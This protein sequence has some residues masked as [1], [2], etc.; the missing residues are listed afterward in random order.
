MCIVKECTGSL[1]DDATFTCKKCGKFYPLEEFAKLSAQV[2]ASTRSKAEVAKWR[3]ARDFIEKVLIPETQYCQRCRNYANMV[4][5]RKQNQERGT[6]SQKNAV[7]RVVPKEDQ[8][9]FERA[10]AQYYI[11]QKI[12]QEREESQRKAQEEA[13]KKQF[14]EKVKASQP[15]PE[16]KKEK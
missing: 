11:Q 12:R 6:S 9:A 4:M 15:K 10:E 7:V 8:K 16:E 5:Q 3:D 13:M 1:K 14:E 2:R